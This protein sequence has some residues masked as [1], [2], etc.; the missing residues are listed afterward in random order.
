MYSAHHLPAL[1]VKLSMETSPI[2]RMV[3]VALFTIPIVVAMVE[4]ATCD[5]RRYPRNVETIF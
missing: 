5:R 3:S 1:N 2:P 4:V